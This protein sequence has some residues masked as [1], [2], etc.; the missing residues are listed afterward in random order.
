MTTSPLQPEK[1][2]PVDYRDE[3]EHA[4]VAAVLAEL[5]ED[6]PARAAYYSGARTAADSIGL[7]HLLTERMD[8]VER[9]TDAYMAH[10]RRTWER[11]RR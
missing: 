5:P 4:E 3:L 2:H 7:G 11:S 8:L 9:L 10:Q 1:R 6:H